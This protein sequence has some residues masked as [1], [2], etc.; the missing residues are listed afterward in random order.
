MQDGF[1]EDLYAAV[2][3]WR[4]AEQFTERER[5]AA[6]YAERFALD[7]TNLDDEFWRRMR[8]AYT[9][10]EILEMTMAI[11]TFISLGRTLAVLDVANECELNWAPADG[12]DQ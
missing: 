12:P 3:Q 7:H 4:S 6:E 10:A 11:G 5:L 1:G 9:D 2:E 8:E